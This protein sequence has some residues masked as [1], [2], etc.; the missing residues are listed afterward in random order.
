MTSVRHVWK[1]IRQGLDRE[2][3]AKDSFKHAIQSDVINPLSTFRVSY[4]FVFSLYLLTNFIRIPMN[5]L[6]GVLKKILNHLHQIIT[7]IVKLFR[8]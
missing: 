6:V 5:V 2:R 4:M 3:Q 7:I 1:E 8:S